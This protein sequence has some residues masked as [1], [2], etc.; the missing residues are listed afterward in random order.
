[1]KS[2]PETHFKLPGMVNC[3]PWLNCSEIRNIK[4]SENIGYGTLKNV[5]KSYWQHHTVALSILKHKKYISDF[6]VGLNMLKLLNGNPHIVQLIGFCEDKNIIVTEYH[7][8]NNAINLKYVIKDS[9]VA[10]RFCLNY[11]EILDTLHTNSFGKLV[12]CDS[13]SLY[14]LLSQFLIT[15]DLKIVLADLDSIQIVTN[16]TV[17]CGSTKPNYEQLISNN[18]LPP[19][20]IYFGWYGDKS[21]IWKVPDICEFFI[22]S[23]HN[24][25]LKYMLFDIHKSCKNADPFKRPSANYLVKKYKQVLNELLMDL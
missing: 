19:E 16:S 10:I 24:V 1:M 6:S 5:F 21:E 4:I 9:L 3:H 18:F 8:Y 12:N 23:N 7:S 2:C 17:I 14:K 20:Q 25:V 13:N 11:V 22:N 15:D